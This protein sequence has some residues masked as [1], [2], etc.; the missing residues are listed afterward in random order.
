MITKIL[1]DTDKRKLERA[2]RFQGELSPAAA[3]AILKM[4]FTEDV[5]NHMRSLLVKARQG[6]LSADEDNEMTAYEQMA[7]LL[8]ILH[9]RARKT[10][11]TSKA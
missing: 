1:K 5:E 9:A 7:C 10:L 2:T 11:K 4:R 8:D 6:T 3:R